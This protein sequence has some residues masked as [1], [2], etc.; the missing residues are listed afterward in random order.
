MW[1]MVR[2]LQKNENPT[3]TKQKNSNIKTCAGAI[4]LPCLALEL[5]LFI[6]LY[7]L[8][9]VRDITMQIQEVSTITF[10][11]SKI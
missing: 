7:T 4:S 2:L 11:N 5:S 9:F 10:V 6:Y 3:T 8:K 1:Q